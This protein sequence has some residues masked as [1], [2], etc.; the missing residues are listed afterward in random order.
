M[1]SH[2]GTGK[3]RLAAEFARDLVAETRSRSAAY[4][5]VGWADVG[6]LSDA[7]QL[8][9]AVAAAVGFPHAGGADLVRALARFLTSGRQLLVLDGCEGLAAACRELADTLLADCPSLVIL[10]TSRVRLRSPL[11]RVVPVRPLDSGSAPGAPERADATI[12]TE[13]GQL[14]LDRA[15]VALPMA[16]RDLDRRQVDAVCRRVGGSP[17]A[18]ELIAA[19]VGEQS[20]AELMAALECGGRTAAGSGDR[21][22]RLPA[23]LSTVCAWLGA[24]E[25]R[26][27]RGLGSFAGDFPREAAESVASGDLAALDALTR[28]C[29]ISRVADLEDATRYRMHPLVRHHAVRML[30]RDPDESAMVRRRHFDY[31]VSRAERASSGQGDRRE[32][33]RPSVQAEYEAA[34]HWALSTGAV[35]PVL[36]LLA[37]LH[38]HE[39]RWSTPSRFQAILEAALAR[40]QDLPTPTSQP[41]AGSIEAAGW[42]AAACGDHELAGQR[43][44]EAAVAYRSLNARSKQAESLRGQ[45]R[46]HLGLGELGAATVC[47]RESLGICRREADHAGAAWSALH[48]AE[49]TSAQGEPE[50]AINQLAL[51]IKEFEELGVPVG[52][53]CGY[54]RLGGNRRV[55]GRLPEAIDA[56]AEAL[57]LGRR[58]QF[59]IDMSDL[60]AGVASVA[61]ELHRPVRAATLLG[62]ARAWLDAFGR[63]SLAGAQGDR[64][65]TERHVRAQIGSEHFGTAVA[66][67]LGLDAAG[68]RA[69]AEQAVAEM[70]S[71]CR[72]LPW[73][74]TEREV[75]VLGLVAEGLTNADIAGR[76]GLSPRTVHAHLR[77]AYGK[78]GVSARTA[79]VRHA[80]S[81]GLL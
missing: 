1:V 49:V 3:T 37:A 76:L 78:L 4:D 62:A 59:T 29:L 65:G 6:P 70:A 38:E 32:L 66:A 60:L 17:L 10:A 42:A 31:C 79:A 36:R 21:R 63:S 25:R 35:E 7:S 30:D 81:L 23:V 45:A 16:R 55:V 28:R 27:L 74:I 80:S 12:P 61:A 41:R 40:A 51:T 47:L 53:Y 58:W 14:F 8:P 54:V 69:E 20:P 67:G 13:A 19:W 39:T 68:T 56:Y 46:A 48:L 43:F 77:S 64:A 5:G 52:A 15:T 22:S 11:E 75:Q 44:A 34:L 50:A 9:H 26:V 2:G 57:E 33:M 24:H 18:I 71:L 72:R 73:G